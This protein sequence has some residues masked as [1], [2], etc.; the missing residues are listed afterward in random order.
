MAANTWLLW[1]FCIFNPAS[2]SPFFPWFAYHPIAPSQVISCGSRSQLSHAYRRTCPSSPGSIQVVSV[3]EIHPLPPIGLYFCNSISRKWILFFP[4][5]FVLISLLLEV[6][7]N[8][9]R[10]LNERTQGQRCKR[11]YQEWKNTNY[12]VNNIIMLLICRYGFI[13][14]VTPEWNTVPCLHTSVSVTSDK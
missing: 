5:V 4:L 11:K 13:N 1:H 2:V 3:L 7:V 6:D 14:T 10:G 8:Q 9:P 12:Y